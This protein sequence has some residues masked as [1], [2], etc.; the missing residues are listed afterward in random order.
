MPAR[1]KDQS[2]KELA[3]L[4]LN[5]NGSVPVIDGGGL[6]LFQSLTINLHLARSRP[7][8]GLWADNEADVSYLLQWTLWA[9][10][11]AEPLALQWLQHTQF[12]A[13]DQRRPRLAELALVQLRCRLAV[14]DQWLSAQP[15]L[16]GQCFTVADLNV[17]SVLLRWADMAIRQNAG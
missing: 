6:V 3:F 10:A 16:L 14:L 15:Y 17:A 13:P 4:A 9:A 7:E 1:Y 11:E 12:L 2:L 5:P 8:G